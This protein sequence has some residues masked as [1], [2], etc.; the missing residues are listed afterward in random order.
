MCRDHHERKQLEA[1]IWAAFHDIPKPAGWP[2]DIGGMRTLS[3]CC[4][5]RQVVN[6]GEIGYA[7]YALPRVMI[8]ALRYDRD[9]VIADLIITLDVE[10]IEQDDPAATF[11]RQFKREHFAKLTSAQRA[12]VA[13]WLKYVDQWCAP[14]AR[15]VPLKSALAYWTNP[16][17][18]PR[19]S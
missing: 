17:A 15:T 18:A 16:S 1:Q 3:D 7:Y 12:A 9:E 10:L 5:G 2:D 14:A 6:M 11:T 13:A 8:C 19:L 4:K